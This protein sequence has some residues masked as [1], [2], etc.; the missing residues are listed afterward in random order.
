MK[1]AE[2]HYKGIKGDGIGVVIIGNTPV[3]CQHVAIQSRCVC[4]SSLSYRHITKSSQFQFFDWK[5]IYCLP[6]KTWPQPECHRITGM[7]TCYLES[8]QKSSKPSKSTFSSVISEHICKKRY[9]SQT[10]PSIFYYYLLFFD[11]LIKQ[12]PHQGTTLHTFFQK[13]QVL[14]SWSWK[15]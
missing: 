3:N 14:D 5:Y 8:I 12:S 7:I 15:M 6:H 13:F 10:T 1:I 9:P 4:P 11:K 2:M